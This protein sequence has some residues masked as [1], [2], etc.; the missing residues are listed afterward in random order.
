ML[1]VLFTGLAHGL[2]S[3][4]MCSWR[5]ATILAITISVRVALEEIRNERCYSR[6]KARCPLRGLNKVKLGTYSCPLG[7][8]FKCSD[9]PPLSIHM[10]VIPPTH[11]IVLK[12]GRK[13]RS[14]LINRSEGSAVLPT[15]LMGTVRVTIS[16][17]IYFRRIKRDWGGEEIKADRPC[18]PYSS[19]DPFQVTFGHDDQIFCGLMNTLVTWM[20]SWSENVCKTTCTI[21]VSRNLGNRINYF[22]TSPANCESLNITYEELPCE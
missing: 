8:Y 14:P 20:F 3:H 22:L 19:G 4:C 5:N 6:Y 15:T 11:G 2:W 7:F 21:H 9:E 18:S 1:V 17:N 12:S 10:G 13:V 16:H